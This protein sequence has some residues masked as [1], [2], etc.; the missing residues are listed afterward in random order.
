MLFVFSSIDVLVLDDAKVVIAS[1]TLLP[2]RFWRMPVKS[3]SVIELPAG[4]ILSSRTA[5]GDTL[6]FEESKMNRGKGFWSIRHYVLF[7]MFNLAVLCIMLLFFFLC[8]FLL[9]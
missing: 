2:W 5:L 8:F 6:S 7:F 1:K 4:T 9:F 3:M